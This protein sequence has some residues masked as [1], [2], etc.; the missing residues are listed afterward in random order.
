MGAITSSSVSVLGSG[1]TAGDVLTVQQPG[2]GRTATIHIVTVDGS[3]VPLTYSLPD[4]GFGVLALRGCGYSVGSA[5]PTSG[6]TGHGFKLDIAGVGPGS[7]SMH[8]SLVFPGGNDHVFGNGGGF[9]VGDTGT[10]GQDGGTNTSAT[11]RVTSV[12]LL[13]AVL[14]MI[15]DGADGYATSFNN[16]SADWGPIFD[17]TNSG[18]QPGVGGGLNPTGFS[19]SACGGGGGSTGYVNRR[20]GGPS[21]QGPP[22]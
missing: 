5:V 16:G 9:V 4:Q 10:L 21:N 22:G 15:V 3:G 7:D 8:G 17:A 13:G 19:I 11:Y 18:P 12:D 20:F 2:S 1:Y 6:G 14:E